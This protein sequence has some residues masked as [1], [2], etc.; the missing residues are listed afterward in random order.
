MLLR[1]RKPLIRVVGDSDWRGALAE[2]NF[3]ANLR[4][5]QGIDD[6]SGELDIG[7]SRDWSAMGLKNVDVSANEAERVKYSGGKKFVGNLAVKEGEGVEDRKPM[8]VLP[9]GNPGSKSD[10]VDVKTKNRLVDKVLV[11]STS[12]TAS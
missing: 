4:Q 5:V 1:A 9:V 10:R 2:E 12:G 6:V 3:K 11:S 8:P 7:N